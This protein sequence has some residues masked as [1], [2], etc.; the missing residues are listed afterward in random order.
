M[1]MSGL[2]TK[3]QR[4]RPRDVPIAT[5][6]RCR[7]SLQRLVRLTVFHPITFRSSHATEKH[8]KQDKAQKKA[9]ISLPSF[10]QQ[11]SAHTDVNPKSSMY[12]FDIVFGERNDQE[13][14][15]EVPISVGK[16]F[17]TLFRVFISPNAP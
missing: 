7:R 1:G 6:V 12:L 17:E 5:A 11:T 16:F 13:R 15:P 14:A 4:R 3:A 9:V 10:S 2:T 8:E